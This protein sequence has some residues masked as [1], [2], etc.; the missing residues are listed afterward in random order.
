ML[1]LSRKEGDS[2]IIGDNIE[3][4]IISISGEKV[5]IGINAPKDISIYRKEIYEQVRK[6]NKS[7]VLEIDIKDIKD[8]FKK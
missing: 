4:F 8:L 6:E 7:S 1:A 5:K 3:I 2:I